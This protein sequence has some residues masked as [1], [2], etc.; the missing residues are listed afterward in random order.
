MLHGGTGYKVPDTENWSEL[1]D[2]VIAHQ[3]FSAPCSLLRVLGG[4]SG[5][6]KDPQ[7]ACLMV[8]HR[9]M[10][11]HRVLV[12]TLQGLCNFNPDLQMIKI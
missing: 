2:L 12:A 6:L 11:R 9:V 4:L 1:Q 8:S 10:A 3:I 5:L 7:L